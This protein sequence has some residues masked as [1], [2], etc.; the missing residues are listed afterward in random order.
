[1][2]QS[3]LQSVVDHLRGATG[4]TSSGLAKLQVKNPDDGERA[5]PLYFYTLAI[6][7]DCHDYSQ[8]SSLPP[9][10]LHS[11][12][13]EKAGTRTPR[14]TSCSSSSSRLQRRTLVSMLVALEICAYS[15]SHRADLELTL[16]PRLLFFLL[17]PIL[18]IPQTSKFRTPGQLCSA[19][20]YTLQLHCITTAA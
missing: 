17:S 3:R 11:A 9:S 16:L 1:M 19:T 14:L 4:A 2:A 7:S 13:P 8:S 6:P 10:E 15:Q 12:K 5:V 20:Y 18:Q